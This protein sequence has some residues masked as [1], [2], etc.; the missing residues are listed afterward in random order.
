[1]TLP[2]VLSLLATSTLLAC[3]SSSD[4]EEDPIPQNGCPSGV[5]GAGTSGGAGVGD[6]GGMSGA[7]GSS[8]GIGGQGG[9]KND[10]FTGYCKSPP[11]PGIGLGTVESPF[12]FRLSVLI[13]P[14]TAAYAQAKGWDIS[15]AIDNQL[16]KL[17]QGF[18]NGQLPYHYQFT[19]TEPKYTILEESASLNVG[20]VDTPQED[21]FV[22]LFNKEAS[23]SGYSPV[24]KKITLQHLGALD[25]TVTTDVL[26]H[27]MAHARGALDMYEIMTKQLQDP[28]I[29]AEYAWQG[30]SYMGNGITHSE[31]W[32]PLTI[33]IF[34]ESA[35]SPDLDALC[36]GMYFISQWCPQT[37][38]IQAEDAS[39]Q[40]LSGASIDIYRFNVG[41]KGNT[42]PPKFLWF[43]GAFDNNGKI[44]LPSG[45]NAPSDYGLGMLF[46]LGVLHHG[47]N[48]YL[49]WY[50]VE[51]LALAYRKGIE[52]LTLHAV[53]SPNSLYKKPNFTYS[54]LKMQAV[55]ASPTILKPGGTFMRQVEVGNDGPDNF[56]GGGTVQ[57]Y[58]SSDTNLDPGI[59]KPSGGYPAIL[60]LAVGAS[61]FFQV[62]NVIPIDMPP[63]TYYLLAS[64]TPSSV[65]VV[66]S[67]P[68]NNLAASAPITVVP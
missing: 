45:I 26:I 7:G 22:L 31:N 19:L 39:Q 33:E 54:D 37:V 65:A 30:S 56:S 48:E 13:A 40:P 32:D 12:Q 57:F 64:Y 50:T 9:Q 29:G 16:N 68:E 3:S 46:Y 60:S 20:I 66:D 6:T 62:N 38:R 61:D 59:D 10:P 67:N 8:G 55:T 36:G 58:L 11:S 42:I 51:D 28:Y 17:H 15:A 49:N 43:T 27:E 14:S 4:H 47:G 23:T 35:G 53:A 18:N 21:D 44:T 1:M 2:V 41:Y 52:D 24:E 34:K 63:G 5:G 25:P